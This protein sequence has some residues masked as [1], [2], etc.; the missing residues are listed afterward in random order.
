M[1]K[2]RLDREQQ[3]LLEASTTSAVSAVG[4]TKGAV[5]PTLFLD[6]L[7]KGV[8]VRAMFDTGALSSIV[9]RDILH[10]IVKHLRT[11]GRAPPAL[12]KP[13]TALFGKDGD[14][15]PEIVVTAQFDAT[16]ERMEKWY[17]QVSLF[18]Q[19]VYNLVYLE[20]M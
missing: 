13:C 15:G 2:R 3:L 11:Q 5:G 9:S 19:I 8:P 20:P 16:I 10:V 1:A 12:R 18:S 14:K 6:V 4:D 17:V 7:I